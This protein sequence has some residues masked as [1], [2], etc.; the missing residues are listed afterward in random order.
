MPRA[1]EQ[2]IKLLVLYDILQRE[3]DE[4]HPLST[5]EIIERL[6][7]RG[8]EVSRKILPG[9][10]ALLNKYGFEILSYKKK[11]HYYYVAYRPFDIAELKVLIDA[12]QAASAR[13]LF[14]TNNSINMERDV[15]KKLTRVND[16]QLDNAHFGRTV[17]KLSEILREKHPV[18]KNAAQEIDDYCDKNFYTMTKENLENFVHNVI[19]NTGKKSIDIEHLPAYKL[20]LLV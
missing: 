9:D 11:S 18:L 1:N 2:K 3:T 4:E 20:G 13:N 14:G 15:I 8:I 6:S 12:V 17:F 16:E 19:K 7:A 5:N 10:I